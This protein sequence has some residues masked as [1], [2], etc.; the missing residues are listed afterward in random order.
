[1]AEKNERTR[2]KEQTRQVD[3]VDSKKVLQVIICVKKLGGYWAPL[4]I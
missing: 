4:Q 3:H 1:M 2:S